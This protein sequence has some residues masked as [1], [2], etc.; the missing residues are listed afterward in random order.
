MSLGDPLRALERG[1]RRR[2]GW[3]PGH[4]KPGQIRG[5][6]RRARAR[7]QWPR[8]FPAAM[9]SL[10]PS[11]HQAALRGLRRGLA[12]L[13]QRQTPPSFT[14][15]PCGVPGSGLRISGRAFGFPHAV[16]PDRGLAPQ[17]GR[18]WER[19]P[20][21]AL[22]RA[23]R[24]RRSCSMANSMSPPPPPP[25]PRGG[26]SRRNYPCGKAMRFTFDNYS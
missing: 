16:Q 12:R 3:G 13:E 14:K 4:P 18:V 26:R 24:R 9:K 20:P 22:P 2:S 11:R 7:T 17:R 25:P 5:H 6:R 19:P 10:D 21:S 1:E 8:A 15:Q 23:S